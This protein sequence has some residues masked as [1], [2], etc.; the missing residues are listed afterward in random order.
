MQPYN[1]QAADDKRRYE[2]R[3]FSPLTRRSTVVVVVV[4]IGA[5]VMHAPPLSAGS[6]SLTGD[7]A[8]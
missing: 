6:D 1:E 8:V 5:R 4:V 3:L 7:R 2:V